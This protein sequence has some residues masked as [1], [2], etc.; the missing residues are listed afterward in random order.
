[1]GV[2]LTRLA[3]SYQLPAARGLVTA[4]KRR[5][6]R[7]VS[8]FFSPS[9]YGSL[10]LLFI[11][12]IAVLLYDISCHLALFRFGRMAFFSFLGAG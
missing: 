8:P 12:I 5:R 9:S 7:T 10:F 6:N 4:P 3:H 1:M 11:L 2:Y